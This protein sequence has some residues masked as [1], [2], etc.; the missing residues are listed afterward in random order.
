MFQI[1]TLLSLMLVISCFGQLSSHDENKI[2]D[3]IY[4]IE[5][6]KSTKYPYGIKS[7]RTRGDNHARQICLN[8]IRN[9]FERW[10]NQRAQNNYFYFLADKYCPRIVDS[11]GNR[12]WRNNI[13]K[14][15]G[16]R[17]VSQI[18]NMRPKN[19]RNARDAPK[20]A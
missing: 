17:F 9:N 12:N 19:I 1:S 14:M 13:V 16:N 20:A 5:G 6:G 7:I 15:L 3:A 18:N 10:Q 4:Q 11:R 8:T 2:A